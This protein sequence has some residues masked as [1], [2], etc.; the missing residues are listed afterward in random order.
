M[1]NKYHIIVIG[2]QMNKSDSERIATYLDDL[3][4]SETD[5]KYGA[6]LV[7]LVTCGVR[8]SAEDRV[9]G[10]APRIKKENPDCKIILTGCLSKRKDVIRRLKSSVDLFLDIT[11]LPKLA[12]KLTLKTPKRY[13]DYLKILAKKKS[14]FSAF[15]PIGNG[16]DNFCSYCVVPYAR[17]REV[18]RSSEDI[19]VEVEDLVS[20]GF[21]EINL[22]AQNVNSYKSG[23]N[24][25]ADLLAIVN[26]IQGDFRIRFITS[27]PKDMSDNLIDVIAKCSKVCEHVHL[28]AQSGNNKVLEK[29]NRGYTIEHYKKLIDKIRKKIP[30]IAISTDI[31][32]GFPGETKEQ[33]DDT[34]KL[35]EYA[36]YD[37]AYISQYSTRPGTAAEKMIDDVSKEDKREREAKLIAIVQKT[38]LKNSENFLGKTIKVLIE[39][40]NRKGELYG[41]TRT[42]KNVKCLG[43]DE[44]IGSIVSVKIDKV[45]DFGISGEVA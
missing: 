4:Y 37:I 14:Q 32:V 35:F 26:D 15:I 13:D 18:Y 29:M 1:K 8:Q 21:K 24:D 31:I 11:D 38:A 45:K 34:C 12:E 3:G 23:E 36:E 41:K 43:D 6:E 22:I 16:C 30:D 10:F 19:V 44:M 33:F 27:H 42:S 39:G 7:I 2:C 17:G 28:P 9:Y 20:R 40:K 25:F 5:D